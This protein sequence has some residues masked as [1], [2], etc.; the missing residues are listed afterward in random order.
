MKKRWIAA[1]AAL[2]L[3]CTMGASQAFAADETAASNAAATGSPGMRRGMHMLELTDEQK[4]QMETERAEREAKL[5]AF[6]EGLNDEQKVLFDAMQPEKSTDSERPERDETAIAEMKA[7]HDAF[8]ATLTEEQKALLEAAQPTRPAT[9][10]GERPEKPDEATM[11]AARAEKEAKLDAFIESL[12]DEQKA[13][14]DALRPTK[15]ETAREKPDEAA[16]ESARAE[17]ETKREAFLASLTDEQKAEWESLM[18][19]KSE[20]GIRNGGGL[21]GTLSTDSS[22]AA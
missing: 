3:V 11:E 2:T 1:V 8:V 9:A 10:N 14:W 12:T 7:Q 15:P 5:E 6:S 22:V 13:A 17:K 18:P 16:M 20:G 21:R 4:A 19:E